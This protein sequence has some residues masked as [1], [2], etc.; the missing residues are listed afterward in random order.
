MYR[1]TATIV[2]RGSA[3]V[4]WFLAGWAGGGFFLY[5]AGVSLEPAPI[6]GFALGAFVFADPAHL[7]WVRRRTTLAD[8]ETLGAKRSADQPVALPAPRRP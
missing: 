7:F 1:T 8:L 6:V 5:L 2:R 3:A 4:L